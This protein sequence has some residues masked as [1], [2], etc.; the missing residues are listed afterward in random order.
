MSEREELSTKT[1]DR[2]SVYALTDSQ[3]AEEYRRLTG[4][5]VQ[6]PSRG[7]PGSWWSWRRELQLRVMQERL[8]T[9]RYRSHT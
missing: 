7:S 2:P 3:L 4:R 5:S 1:A 8:H 6:V 9:R